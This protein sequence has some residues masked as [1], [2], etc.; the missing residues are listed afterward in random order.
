[1]N[2]GG[3]VVKK[4]MPEERMLPQTLEKRGA[5]QRSGGQKLGIPGSG[6]RAEARKYENRATCSGHHSWSGERK[7][8]EVGGGLEP[9][10]V[11]VSLGI[12]CVDK[13]N[14]CLACDLE[15]LVPAGQHG[16]CFSSGVV[17]EPGGLLEGR[18]SL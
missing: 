9:C 11:T 8:L 16:Y 2:L 1:M 18:G 5:R 6:K 13:T 12:L 10:A 3:W 14:E 17:Q 7:G 15:L 4:S